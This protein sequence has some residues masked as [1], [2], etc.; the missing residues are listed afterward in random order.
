MRVKLYLSLLW[1]CAR[2]P[3]DVARPARAWA[4]LLGLPDPAGRGARRIHQAFKD[5]EARNFVELEERGGLPTRV[6]LLDETGD[7]SP[8][9]PASDA[10]GRAMKL[11]AGEDVL[12]RHRYFRIDS[13]LWTHGHIAQLRGPALAMLLVLLSERRGQ[14]SPWVWFSP[15]R[16]AERF[17]LSA[18]TRTDGLRQLRDLGLIMT[19]SQVVSERGSYIDYQRRRNVHKVIL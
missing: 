10:Y 3:Y 4:A 9:V 12:R 7:G 18:S 15:D 19:K 11:G 14:E 5:L 2:Q 13:G 16:A 1:V 8:F 6:T 17:S